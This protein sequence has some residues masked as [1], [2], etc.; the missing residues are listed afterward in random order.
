MFNKQVKLGAAISYVLIMLNACYGLFLTPFIVEQLGEASYG[1]YKTIS[2]FT[3]SLMVLDLGLGGT[4]MRYIAKFRADHEEEKIPNFVFM[5]VVQTGAVCVLAGVV[6]AVLYFFLGD[7]YHGGLTL[8]EL[9]LAKKLYIFLAIALISHIIENLLNGIISGHNHFVFANG[10]KLVRLLVRILAV[11]IFLGIFKST[12]VL[13][14]IDLTCTLLF[15]FA[16]LA[17]IAW[18]LKLKVRYSHWD[19]CV[20]SE[21]FR[22]TI[23]MFLTSIVAQANSNFG[24]IAIGALINSASV[25]VYSMAVLVFGMYEQLSTAISGVML[26]TITNT[27]KND[28]ERYTNTS[29]VVCGAGRVQFLLLGAVFVG[30]IVLGKPFV[31]LWLGEGFEDV[32]YLVLI[33]LGPALLELC[34]NVC[35]SVLRAKNM[36]G[37]RTLV[38]AL[39][40][41]LNIT[42]CLLGMRH[43]GYYAAALG[44]AC[45]FLFGSVV[46]MGI[47]YYKKL[48]ISIIMLYKSIFRNIWICLLLSGTAAWGTTMLVDSLLGKFIGGTA[49]FCLVY[50]LGLLCFGLN[51][52][53]KNTIFTMLRRTRNG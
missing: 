41:V 32:Y 8:A 9:E 50:A 29:K 51:K 1:V 26:P 45:S 5:G 48:G 52:S 12:V 10:I 17:Y 20:F 18:C 31:E 2:A 43:I 23:L 40:T 46:V 44:T 3:A 33:L 49:V 19:W 7:I 13:V 28:D 42:I 35:L 4:M 14:I 22:Y 6:T 11:V 27:L 16:E 36:L 53:E 30:F 24:N 34:I 25:T 39:A 15:V 21:S 47:Y 38:I 37:F